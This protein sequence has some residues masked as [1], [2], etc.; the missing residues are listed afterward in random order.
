VHPFDVPREATYEG[1]PVTESTPSLEFA[2]GKVNSGGKISSANRDL[3]TFA[4]YHE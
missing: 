2:V 3:E 4:V 1:R